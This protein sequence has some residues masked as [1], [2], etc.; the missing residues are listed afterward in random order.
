MACKLPQ[1]LI[2]ICY[3]HNLF[4]KR[5]QNSL[6]MI[7]RHVAIGSF[8]N[9]TK[10][11][12]KMT[13]WMHAYFH[14]NN[15]RTQNDDNFSKIGNL[16]RSHFLFVNKFP[17]V[18]KIYKVCKKELFPNNSSKK[19]KTKPILQKNYCIGSL[20]KMYRNYYKKQVILWNRN[21]LNFN[22]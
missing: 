20:K 22:F 3:N 13:F 8:K 15:N 9:K 14:L 10:M 7:R 1:N 17:M 5:C 16:G 21:T 18:S 2:L 12:Q 11:N 6:I 19:F 4:E